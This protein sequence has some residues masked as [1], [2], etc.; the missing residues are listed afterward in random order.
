MSVMNQIKAEIKQNLLID[1]LELEDITAEEIADDMILFGEG[2]GLD[3][4]EAFEVMVGLE[5]CYGVMVEGIPADELKEHLSTVE[6]I[7]ALVI[8]RHTKGIG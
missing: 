5:E 1:R 8:S 4:V 2:L 6:S 7:A 3:S